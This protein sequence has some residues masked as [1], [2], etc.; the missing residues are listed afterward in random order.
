MN[1]R[2][3]EAGDG[4]GGFSPH[5]SDAAAIIW[6]AFGWIFVVDAIER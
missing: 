5:L 3:T 1:V 2:T 6:L 4:D